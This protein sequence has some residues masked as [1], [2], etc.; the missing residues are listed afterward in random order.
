LTTGSW[1]SQGWYTTFFQLPN[2][3]KSLDSIVP[4]DC[5][6]RTASGQ[7][8]GLVLSGNTPQS[9]SW[10]TDKNRLN[11]PQGSLD[12]NGN[13]LQ[14]NPYALTYDAE[15]RLTAVTS[16]SNGSASYAYDGEG[17]RVTKRP[18]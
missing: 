3:A 15:N 10:F 12:L 14:M 17:R 11:L 5:L 8:N 7:S 4:E 9:A 2:D 18:A 16:Q 1:S 13:Q 6:A